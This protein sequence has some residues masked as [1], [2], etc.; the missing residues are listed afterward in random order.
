M[1][2]ITLSVLLSVG[3]LSSASAAKSFNEDFSGGDFGPNLSPSG[4]SGSSTVVDGKI[5]FKGR[6]D[7][8][9]SWVATN[10]TDYASSSF[11]A[12]VTIR[13]D[14]P[15]ESNQ[16]THFIGLGVGNDHDSGGSGPVFDEPALGP[17]AYF[18]VCGA[19]TVVVGDVPHKAAKKKVG[20]KVKGLN[21]DRGTYRLNLIYDHLAQTLTLLVDGEPFGTVIDTSDNQYDRTNAR[22]FIGSTENNTFDDVYVDIPE[23]SMFPL[24]G[25]LVALSCVMTRR[26]R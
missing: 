24:I 18:G 19:N 8:S 4:G 3:I 26:R 21:L 9:R 12:Q 22:I 15:E 13:I 14:D 7:D 1:K 16:F 20:K 23:S 11:N 17:S 2:S 6:G 5:V 25:G 10:D